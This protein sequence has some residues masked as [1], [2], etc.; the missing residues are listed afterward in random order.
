MP[1]KQKHNQSF[2]TQSN[3]RTYQNKQAS[4]ETE[5]PSIDNFDD[6]LVDDEAE[7]P[8]TMSPAME[9]GERYHEAGKRD[10]ELYIRTYNTLLRS[11]G[12]ISLKAL[13]QAHYNIG[14]SLHPDARQPYPDMSAFIYSVLRLPDAVSQCKR[15]L[16]GQSEEV[17]QQQGYHVDQWQAVTASARRRKWFYDGKETLAAYVASVSDTDDIVPTLVAFQIEW[18]KI[19]YLLKADPTT[20]ELL[21]TRVEHNS[22]VYAEISKV[23]R[24]R[25]HIAHDDWDRLEVIWGNTLWEKLHEIGQQKKDYNL[26]MLGGSHVGFVKATHQWWYPVKQLLD[27]LN[28]QDRPVYFVSSNTHSLVNLLSGFTLRHEKVLTD[29]ARS[30]SDAYLTEEASKIQE[31]TVP[32][33]WHNFL[34]FAAREWI[35]TQDGKEA[36]R[37]RM[38]E[39]QDRGIWHVGARHG[40]EIDAQIFELSKLQANDIDPRSRMNHLDLLTKSDAVILNIDYPLGMA[41]YR[42]MREIMENLSQIR[43]IYILG[44]AATLNGSIGDVMISNVIMDEHS[45]NTYWLDNAF[46]AQNVRP[47]LIYGS[48]LDNQKAISAKGTFLQNRHYLDFYYQANYTVVEME[49]G[50]YLNAIYEDQYLTRYPTN[51]NINLVRIPYELGILHYSSDTPFTR[52]KNLGAGSLSYFGMDSTYASTVAIVRRIFEREIQEIQAKQ[53]RQS[54]ANGKVQPSPKVETSTT[55]DTQTDK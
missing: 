26:R 18:N 12:E 4:Y 43:G 34:Y 9:Y 3:H 1:H 42:M 36:A 40:L 37:T 52:G 11:S 15:V 5:H 45:Q 7:N 23:L 48:V 55:R 50:P 19:Y 20:M 14:S 17:F 22:T 51:D 46:T 25:L 21:E 35:R 6:E 13:V 27:S 28:L 38:Q 24:H 54:S 31:G 29:F 8:T 33:N 16:L 32:G 44:K 30:G 41:A 53:P 49:S 39:A 47:Y 2:H 10:V